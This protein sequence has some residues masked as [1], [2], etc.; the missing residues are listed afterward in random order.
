M[1]EDEYIKIA[2]TAPTKPLDVCK[3]CQHLYCE[4]EE[5]CEHEDDSKDFFCEQVADYVEGVR[6]NETNYI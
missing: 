5:S 1:T 4:A 3:G 6:Q 2:E